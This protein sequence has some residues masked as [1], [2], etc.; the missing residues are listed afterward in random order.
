MTRVVGRAVSTTARRAPSR[1]VESRARR[2]KV[3]ME[4]VT[5]EKKKLRSVVCD[6][7]IFLFGWM[8]I[9]PP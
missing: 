7:F 4:S 3:I 2:H 6:A 5:Q 9:L 8:L 1:A